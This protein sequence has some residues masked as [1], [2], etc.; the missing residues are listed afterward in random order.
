MQQALFLML[1]VSTIRRVMLRL[2]LAD[3]T[4]GLVEAKR[5]D[6]KL[7][8]I[9]CTD[10]LGV[11]FHGAWSISNTLLATASHLA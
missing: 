10:A 2:Y 7:A 9:Q 4:R 1:Q 3:G 8:H 5:C 11:G 6:G